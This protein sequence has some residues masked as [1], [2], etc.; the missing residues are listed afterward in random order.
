MTAWGANL[1]T[2]ALAAV[3]GSTTL[4]PAEP[5]VLGVAGLGMAA[6]GLWLCLGTVVCLVDLARRR[7][8]LASGSLRPRVLRH[9]LLRAWCPAVGAAVVC[10]AGPV[11]ADTGPSGLPV[12]DRPVVSAPADDS[13]QH[14]HPRSTPR[15]TPATRAVTGRRTVVPGDCLW[16]IAEDLLRPSPSPAEVDRGW[17]SIYRLN[18]SRLGPD[19]DVLRPGTRLVLPTSLHPSL[20]PSLPPSR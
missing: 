11:A 1:A 17:R 10:A 16:T 13:A 2:A 3:T 8:V 18:R 14:D 15:R 12:P 20:R 19:P 7:T 6:V 5:L 9:A 4:T